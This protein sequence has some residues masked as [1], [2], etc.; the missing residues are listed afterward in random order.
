MTKTTNEQIK[1]REN[2]EIRTLIFM[3]TQIIFCYLG[4]KWRAGKRRDWT[5]LLK[6][7][8]LCSKKCKIPIG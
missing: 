3:N 5:H 1:K 8:F 4:G 7:D 2:Y 6:L